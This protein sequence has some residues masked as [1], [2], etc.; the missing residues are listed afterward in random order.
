[1]RPSGGTVTMRREDEDGEAAFR[2]VA[3]VPA[4]E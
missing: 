3:T 4:D 1:L 2:A